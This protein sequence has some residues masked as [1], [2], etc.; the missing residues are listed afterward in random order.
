MATEIS[1][2]GRPRACQRNQRA[3]AVTCRAL[4][5]WAWVDRPSDDGPASNSLRIQRRRG[6]RRW[7]AFSSLPPASVSAGACTIACWTTEE[8]EGEVG[9]P[10]F[11]DSS[12]LL[13][14]ARG[15]QA[16]DERYWRGSSV[17]DMH[18]YL[19]ASPRRSLVLVPTGLHESRSIRLSRRQPVA[20]PD[21]NALALILTA[22]E[23]P[24]C[25]P[26]GGQP[27]KHAGMGQI[28]AEVVPVSSLLPELPRLRRLTSSPAAGCLGLLPLGSD[29]FL[30]IVTFSTEVGDLRPGETVMRVQQTQFYSLGSAAW[31][32]YSS[33]GGGVSSE[34]MDTEGKVSPVL[35]G[36]QLLQNHDP[37]ADVRRTLSD[38]TFHYADNA[39]FDL[40]SPISRRHK[41]DSA[42]DAFDGLASYD[43]DFVWN[44]ALLAPL[45]DGVRACL[46]PDQQIKID[47][48]GLFLP[49]IRG[50]VGVV[51]LPPTYPLRDKPMHLALVS[52]VGHNRPGAGPRNRGL[53]DDGN[54]ASFVEVCL[55]SRALECTKPS[56]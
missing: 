36:D 40:S 56:Y 50:S 13:S 51:R 1:D 44:Q 2:D 3:P 16:Q 49:I 41:P 43:E 26:R 7:N 35:C 54:A 25:V 5:A 55:L 53:D 34:E 6:A 17:S 8:E 37:C 47:R 52:R 10:S 32:G 33:S 19:R 30:S 39:K 27:D 42:T 4:A 22:A 48:C 23:L 12:R 18:L 9:R 31:D 28:H 46:E 14:L 15:P 11:A 38:G 45:L 29:V 20:V 24:A 21:C